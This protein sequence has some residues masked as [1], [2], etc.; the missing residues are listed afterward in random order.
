MIAFDF[1]E[2]SYVVDFQRVKRIQGYVHQLA[3]KQPLTGTDKIYMTVPVYAT[4]PDTK[5]LVREMVPEK[6]SK[7]WP[8]RWSATARFCAKDTFSLEGGRVH[9]LRKLSEETDDFPAGAA[10]ALWQAYNGRYRKN[11][12]PN[13]QD[14]L[15][16]IVERLE[17][18]QKD[19]RIPKDAVMVVEL[20]F[21]SLRYKLT[22]LTHYIEGEE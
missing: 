9:A 15:R 7:D 13:I 19:P 16:D 11:T 20:T 12:K 2:K 14:Q 1:Q 8:I 10:H 4:Y 5:V 18:L 21:R 6:T 3:E 17:R 22:Q